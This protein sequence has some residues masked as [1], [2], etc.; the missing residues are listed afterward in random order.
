MPNPDKTYFTVNLPQR[1]RPKLNELAAKSMR[2]RP[3]VIE[4]LIEQ[5]I[6]NPSLLGMPVHPE[7]PRKPQ[8]APHA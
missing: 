3:Q 7:K 8:E 2:S 4:V 5:A 1:C 6:R